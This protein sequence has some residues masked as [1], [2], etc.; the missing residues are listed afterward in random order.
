[1]QR[2]IHRGIDNAAIQHEIRN[3]T[4]A[5]A[6]GGFRGQYGVIDIQGPAGRLLHLLDIRP[7]AAIARRFLDH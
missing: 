5:I 7:Y 2:M 1:M 6:R 4:I 3:R